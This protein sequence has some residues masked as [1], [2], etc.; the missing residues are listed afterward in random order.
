MARIGITVRFRPW[1]RFK[2]FLD[3]KL[4]DQFLI[5]VER[6]S[7]QAFRRGM[8]G[9]KSGILRPGRKRA[10]AP[11][12]YPAIQ[13][14]RLYD[15]IRATRTKR[16]VRVSTNRPYSGFLASGTRYMAARKM[17]KDALREGIQAARESNPRGFVRWKAQT[18]I[19][20]F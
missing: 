18:Q 4:I 12:E 15:T 20:R 10:S 3:Q 11:G 9:P 8:Q 1:R 6:E 5:S 19:R 16:I 17:S 14:K 13:S 7:L 2:A